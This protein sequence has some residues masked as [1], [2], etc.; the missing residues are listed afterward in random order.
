[1]LSSPPG[2]DD[3]LPV[4]L[5]GD[6]NSLPLSPLVNFI[7]S[8]ALD[9]SNLSAVVIAGYKQKQ[10]ARSIP[11]PLLPQEMFI[12]GNCMYKGKR[13]RPKTSPSGGS[14]GGVEHAVEHQEGETS[15]QQDVMGSNAEDEAPGHL[16]HPFT[17]ISAYP[18]PPNSVTTFHQS[19]FETVDYIFYT[20]M[21]SNSLTGF[22]L[23]QRQALLSRETLRS[24]GPL[25]HKHI[26]S[27]HLRLQATFQFAW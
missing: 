19:A 6:L 11:K 10:S 9:Y 3:I 26:S 4:L 8:S 16:S 27:D 12:G 23:L 24:L 17:L 22:H 18:R 2:S 1:M 5:C 13:E 25:P 21:A 15:G 7:T 14:T 20:P